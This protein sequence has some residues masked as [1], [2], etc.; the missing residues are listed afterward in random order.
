M[1]TT[2][3]VFHMHHDPAEMVGRRERLGVRLLIVADG[4]L[5]FGLIFSYLYMRNLDA[6]HAWRP[7]GVEP[8]STVTSW[9][10]AL[11]FVVAMALHAFGSQ[12]PSARRSTSMLALAVLV[13]GSYLQVLVLS[14]APLLDPESGRF[15]GAYLSMWGLLGGANLFHYLLSG[16]IALGLMLRAFRGRVDPELEVWRM[17]TA[18]SWFTWAAVSAAACA[19]TLLL[20]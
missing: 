17:R 20:G 10:L 5:V 2:E 11:P 18:Q 16:F 9:M 14:S 19:L 1:T 3:P 6:N 4:A 8:L 12:Q 13:L 15:D 7:E